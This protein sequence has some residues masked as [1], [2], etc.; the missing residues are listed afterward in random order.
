M[1]GPHILG[2]CFVTRLQM[3][4]MALQSVNC[5]AL[6]LDAR[7]ASTLASVGLVLVSSISGGSFRGQNCTR[8]PNWIVRGKFTWL[9]VST[10][11]KFALA[12]DGVHA[13][14]RHPQHLTDRH[15]RGKYHE[16]GE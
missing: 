2:G 4:M 16:H 1:L 6:A 8:T 3:A 15:S 12:G 7:Y 11:P 9:A 14:R 13:D 5:L 10:T